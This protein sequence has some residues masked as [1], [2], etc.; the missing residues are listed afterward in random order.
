M[1]RMRLPQKQHQGRVVK[2]GGGG[3]GGVRLLPS[4]SQQVCGSPAVE[5]MAEAFL[6][7]DEGQQQA[8]CQG[9]GAE[10]GFDEDGDRERD[11]E[12]GKET[13]E[14]EE[15]METREE[16]EMEMDGAERLE[17]QEEAV[18]G[19]ELPVDEVSAV[20]ENLDDFLGGAWDLD[21]ELARAR[22]GQEREGGMMGGAGLMDVGVWD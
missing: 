17:T 21:A 18:L 12:C 7:G 6:R 20:M 4:G 15:E 19:E 5:A 1:G 9:E 10:D 22:A 13:R 3:V 14:E 16:V 8:G 11:V 2:R